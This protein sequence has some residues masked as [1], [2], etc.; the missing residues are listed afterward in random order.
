[1]QVIANLVQNRAQRSALECNETGVRSFFSI[2][3]SRSDRCR[4]F[5]LK[6]ASVF[7]SKSCSR[8]WKIIG[9]IVKW[10]GIL[11][12]THRLDES[13]LLTLDGLGTI[14]RWTHLPQ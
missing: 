4:T 7:V 2:S 3:M 11:D 13:L 14:Y 6:L 9:Y 1:M 5:S 8:I 12:V 10:N